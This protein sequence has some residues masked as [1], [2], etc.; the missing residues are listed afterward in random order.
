MEAYLFEKHEKP[1]LPREYKKIFKKLLQEEFN[2]IKEQFDLKY[3]YLPITTARK[4]ILEQLSVIS[5]FLHSLD[6][7]MVEPDELPK[8]EMM[9][10]MDLIGSFDE[11]LVELETL[12]LE[13]TKD[14]SDI[15]RVIKIIEKVGRE[16]PGLF[17][18]IWEKLGFSF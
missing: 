15:H 13:G 5:G 12:Q 7:E 8:K 17:N 10:L 18:T 9:H 14:V 1:Y 2:K 16:L 4:K 3:A 6:E 11:M